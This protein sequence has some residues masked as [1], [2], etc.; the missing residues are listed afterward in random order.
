LIQFEGE[1]SFDVGIKNVKR[2]EE[3]KS[4][5]LK[6]PPLKVK[7]LGVGGVQY[8]LSYFSAQLW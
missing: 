2:I 7:V 3:V 8:Y 1:P 5:D 6:S 4:G